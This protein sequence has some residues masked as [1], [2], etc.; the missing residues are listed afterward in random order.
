[1]SN[2]TPR[3]KE[4]LKSLVKHPGATQ[5]GHARYMGIAYSTLKTHAAL[6]H[7]RIGASGKSEALSKVI[8]GEVEID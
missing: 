4:Y 5:R 3:Q 2:L 8:R 1:M 7:R 6:A